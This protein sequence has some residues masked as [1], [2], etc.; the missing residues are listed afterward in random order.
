MCETGKKCMNNAEQGSMQTEDCYCVP[1]YSFWKHHQIDMERV[2]KACM[3]ISCWKGVKI[4][5]RSQNNTSQSLHWIFSS[6]HT[7]TKKRSWYGF[8]LEVSGILCR[9]GLPLNCDQAAVA[10]TVDYGRLRQKHNGINT[11]SSSA[12]QPL[13]HMPG[14]RISRTTENRFF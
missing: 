6:A 8:K 9:L 13:P 4:H 1:V 11:L 2:Q 5:C 10:A 7:K 14:R 3:V 12:M